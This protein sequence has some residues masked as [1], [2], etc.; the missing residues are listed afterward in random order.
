M[1]VMGIVK[2]HPYLV[3]G[4]V[5][6]IVFLISASRGSGTTQNADSA[7]AIGASLSSQDMASRANVAIAGINADVAKNNNAAYASMYGMGVG[8]AV[9]LAKSD[10][11]SQVAA[12]ANFLQSGDNQSAIL[13]NK[14]TALAGISAGLKMSDMQKQVALS[15]IAS[16]LQ[17]SLNKDATNLKMLETTTV[18]NVQ[19]TDKLISGDYAKSVLGAG[20]ARDALASQERM[21]GATIGAQERETSQI[22]NFQAATLPTLLQHDRNIATMANET[23]R[24]TVDKQSATD[25][26]M[27][28]IKNQGLLD[29]THLTGQ[30]ELELARID[31]DVSK[32]TVTK[33]TDAQRKVS[34]DNLWQQTIKEI[35][36]GVAA[37]FASDIR[38]KE[39]II[40]IGKSPRG[41]NWYEFNFKGDRQKYQG[42]MAQEVQALDPSAVITRDGFLAVDY[43]KV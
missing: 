36:K 31:A 29:F 33:Q 6:L 34:R 20:V 4:G 14:T 12:F 25:V 9:D 35:G 21:H 26:Q 8:A 23:Q 41:Y 5:L 32:W 10:Q 24:Y 39:N 28:Q 11:L 2:E 16:S 13:A 37:Y 42:V 22:L 43:N 30:T 38:L 40:C 15:D 3:G 18:A 1:D 17:A 7:A 19:M 27:T